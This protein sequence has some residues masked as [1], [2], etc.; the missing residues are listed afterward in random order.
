MSSLSINGVEY[1][2]RFTYNERYDYWSFGLYGENYEPIIAMTRIVPNFPLFHFY[3]SS[4]IPDGVF[5]CV[6]D[7]DTVG[8][9]AFKNKTAEF[10]YIP[11]SELE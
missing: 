9:Y 4:D 6:S 2:L 10:V 5:G 7:I 1:V 3:T 11:K 8:R